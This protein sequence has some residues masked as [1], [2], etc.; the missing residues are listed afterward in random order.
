MRRLRWVLFLTAILFS[1]SSLAKAAD[2]NPLN[3]PD[4]QKVL[5]AMNEFH[6]AA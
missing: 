2:K 3:D 1:A 6:C 4:V 5:R